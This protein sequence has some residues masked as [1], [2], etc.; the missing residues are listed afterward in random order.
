MIAPRFSSTS[1]ELGVK[2]S[3]T[4]EFTGSN[5]LFP[6][7]VRPVIRLTIYLVYHP[8]NVGKYLEGFPQFI[9]LEKNIMHHII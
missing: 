1:S 7:G 9:P 4:E 3:P 5:I 8:Q 6:L 2:L